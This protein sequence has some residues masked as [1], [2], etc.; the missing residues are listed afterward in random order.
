[1]EYKE[2][3]DKEFPMPRLGI[4]NNERALEVTARWNSEYDSLESQLSLDG[5]LVGVDRV[6]DYAPTGRRVR[7][8]LR[9]IFPPQEIKLREEDNKSRNLGPRRIHENI[10]HEFNPDEVEGYVDLY[11]D[12]FSNPGSFAVRSLEGKSKVPDSSVTAVN[13][14]GKI[15]LGSPSEPESS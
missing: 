15:A 4:A 5:T 13:N 6:V 11:I 1:M 3:E 9:Y 8:S 12:T 10:A 2:L 7:G 14:V